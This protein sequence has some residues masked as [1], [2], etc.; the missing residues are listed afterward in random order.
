MDIEFNR[1]TTGKQDAV[2]KGLVA[3]WARGDP[4]PQD[5]SSHRVVV[6]FLRTLL[7]TSV[8]FVLFFFFLAVEGA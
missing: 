3:K 2:A 1:N 6:S 5:P 8:S 7:S 4:V